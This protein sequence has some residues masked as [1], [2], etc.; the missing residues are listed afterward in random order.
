MGNANTFL[1]ETA[2]GLTREAVERFHVKVIP[3]GT[4]IVSF[5]L[6]M[7]QVCITTADM[8]TNEAIAHFRTERACLREYAYCYL[9]EFPYDTLGSTSGISQDVN[10]KVIKAMPF[11]LPSRPV[12][13][14][15]SHLTRPFFDSIRV[16]QGLSAR[17]REARDRLL[18]KLMSGEMEV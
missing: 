13:E 5:K 17:L 7:G 10:S 2:E 1:F 18:P 9:K 8:C 11:V 15:F 4:V 16:R 6:T 14:Q 3:A 12:L